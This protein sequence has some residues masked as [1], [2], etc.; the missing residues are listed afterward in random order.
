[1]MFVCWDYFDRF[2]AV[3]DKYLP[4]RGE[5]ETFATQICTAVNKLIYKWYN[6]GDVYDNT[7][8]G[9]TGWCN[10]LSDY[11]NWLANVCPLAKDILDDIKTAESDDDYEHILKALADYFLDEDY[12]DKMNALPKKGTIYD[13]KGEYQF[14]EPT[15][16]DEYWWGEDEDEEGDE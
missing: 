16:E 10:D 9:L 11:A 8:G 15:E 7:Y 1:M 3:N 2:E 4:M 12:L 6:D 14:V 13:C 5:G